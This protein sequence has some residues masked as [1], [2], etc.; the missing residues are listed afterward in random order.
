MALLAYLSSLKL[1]LEVF[2]AVSCLGII[3]TRHWFFLK[4]PR[5]N[6]DEK[7]SKIIEVRR[8]LQ[9]VH[10]I[11]GS[12]LDSAVHPAPNRTRGLASFLLSRPSIAAVRR[13]WSE[14]TWHVC[15]WMLRH[16]DRS[17]FVSLNSSAIGQPIELSRDFLCP[18]P[19]PC[20]IECV[21]SSWC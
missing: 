4:Q 6:H 13:P 10:G 16:N 14:C 12:D 8:V 15:V 7:M 3:E 1:I 21:L 2:D 9:A 20:Q 18:E 5:P 17:S 11:P 19:C